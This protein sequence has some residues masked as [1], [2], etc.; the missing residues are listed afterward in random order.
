M[1]GQEIE[2]TFQLFDEDNNAIT[3]SNDAS[4]IVYSD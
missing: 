3:K 2:V 4:I 1:S